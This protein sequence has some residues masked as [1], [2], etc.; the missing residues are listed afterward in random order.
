LPGQIEETVRNL[1]E[2]APTLY[3]NVPKGYEELVP[4]LRRDRALRKTFFSR[5]RVLQFGGASL[6]R[7]VFD[8]FDEL[9]LDTVGER[10]QWMPVFAS[11]EAGV[12]TACRDADVA[13]A[14]GIGLPV[15]SVTLKFVPNDGRLEV[16][17]QSPCVTPG[18]WRRQDLT[19]AAFDKDG[20]F[21]TGDALGWMNAAN[22]Q[23]GLRY[24]GRIAED[25][26]LATGTWVRVSALRE[27]LLR[28]LAPEVRD[29]VIA[30]ENRNYIAVLAVPADPNT[31]DD[32]QLHARLR[33]KLTALADHAGGS[34]QRVLRLMFL[35][36]KL[37]IDGGE[38]T[39]KGGLNQRNIL[40]RHSALVGQLYAD[41]PGDRV[42]HVIPG[43]DGTPQ[44]FVVSVR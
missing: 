11:T 15:P 17:V 13:R 14:G 21:R 22:P 38:L 27:N 36:A 44:P 30:G 39:D 5:V 1:R 32:P 7:H 29:L 3:S 43:V 6:A 10:I 40:R 20:F 24:R 8:A 41:A 28:H 37:S 33:A 35:T 16:R 31:V 34:A 19:S 2:V 26:K 12:I 4:W 9:A 23:T 18:Y 42:I 25:F